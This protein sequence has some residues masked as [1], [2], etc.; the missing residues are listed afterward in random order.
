MNESATA[1]TDEGEKKGQVCER[2]RAGL[3]GKEGGCWLLAPLPAERSGAT[4][5]RGV[6]QIRVRVSE[7]EYKRTKTA[8]N[9]GE[10]RRR[11]ARQREKNRARVRERARA[12]VRKR[13]KKKEK[14]EG[15]RNPEKEPY[16][17]GR[18]SLTL[19]ARSRWPARGTSK[20][21]RRKK[22]KRKRKRKSRREIK[23]STVCQA[24]QQRE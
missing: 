9:G 19:C 23:R 5:N 22:K 2:N 18:E 21:K 10:K 20:A 7:L 12:R 4:D 24:R 6:P 17:P 8:G 1:A 3:C 16:G 11:R 15:E 14:K 13:G